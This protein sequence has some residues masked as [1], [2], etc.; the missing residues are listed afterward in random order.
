MAVNWNDEGGCFLRVFQVQ[1]SGERAHDLESRRH[2]RETEHCRPKGL[3]EG[4]KSGTK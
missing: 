3:G 2:F 4:G 1:V